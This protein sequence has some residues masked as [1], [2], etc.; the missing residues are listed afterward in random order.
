MLH[1]HVHYFDAST[2]LVLQQVVPN[3]SSR[4]EYEKGFALGVTMYVN[5]K[6]F[7]ATILGVVDGRG[8]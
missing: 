8:R 5:Y 6:P 2:K 3:Y 1:V 7:E 4:E